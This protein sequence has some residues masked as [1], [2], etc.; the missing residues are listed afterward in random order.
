MLGVSKSVFVYSIINCITVVALVSIRELATDDIIVNINKGYAL[1]RIGTYSTN[2]VEEVVHTFLSLDNFCAV[3]TTNAVCKYTSSS[4]TTNII[5]LATIITSD[6]I[7]DT[8]FSYDRDNVSQLI[9]KDLNRVLV[10][11]K[12]DEFLRDTESNVHFINNKFYYNNNAAK[13]SPAT[14]SINAVD[15]NNNNNN[16]L[17]FRATSVDMIIKQINNNRISFEYLSLVDLK[18]FLTIV[19]SNL[20]NSYKINDVED[21][22]NAFSQIAVG[23]SIYALRYCGLNRQHSLSSKP[24]LVISTLF[25]RIPSNSPSVYSIYRLFPLPVVTN[26]NKYIYSDLPKIIGI[27]S[28]EQTLIRTTR[29]EQLRIDSSIDT[30]CPLKLFETFERIEFPLA[31]ETVLRDSTTHTKTFFDH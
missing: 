31:I 11:H 18:L 27:N 15:N 23:Q 21:S 28:I 12:S 1:Q 30:Q 2:M 25:I 29:I 16:I 8:S 9:A 26:D 3:Q 13:L 17:Q 14:T 6:H 24:C 20:D 5:E 10:Q 4:S 7:R 19:F 22:L